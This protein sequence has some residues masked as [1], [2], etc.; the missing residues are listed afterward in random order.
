MS[1]NMEQS[2]ANQTQKTESDQPILKK[3][4]D[5]FYAVWNMELA[6]QAVVQ[7]LSAVMQQELWSD[8]YAQ[9]VFSRAPAK[10]IGLS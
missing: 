4:S 1:E 7:S 8:M 9:Q 3:L 6:E 5:C 2:F 10:C